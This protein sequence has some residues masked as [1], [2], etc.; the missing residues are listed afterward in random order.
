MS[1]E[2]QKSVCNLLLPEDSLIAELRTPVLTADTSST[3]NTSA[4]SNTEEP[5]E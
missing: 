2:E 4:R 5:R 1:K 3:D